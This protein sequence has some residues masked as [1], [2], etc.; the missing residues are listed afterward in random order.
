MATSEDGTQPC[1]HMSQ[2]VAIAALSEL[3]CAAASRCR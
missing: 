3:Q 2:L 1:N